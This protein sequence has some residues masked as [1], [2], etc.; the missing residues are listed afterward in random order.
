MKSTKIDDSD[1]EIIGKSL[2]SLQNLRNLDLSGNIIRNTGASQL[3][4]ALQQNTKILK[5]HLQGNIDIRQDILD[6][7]ERI[8]KRNK[9]VII[10]ENR[11]IQKE[12]IEN[13]E[14]F[15][16]KDY[17][18]QND[19][20]LEFENLE[21]IHEDLREKARYLKKICGKELEVERM[22]QKEKEIELSRL[23]D[24]IKTNEDR[25]KE[26]AL[27]LSAFLS[28]N[29]V[30]KAEKE[31]L[32]Q[33]FQLIQ[34]KNVQ[35]LGYI[36]MQI[37]ENSQKFL[38]IDRLHKE[39]FLHF[40]NENE[41]IINQIIG[42]YE[43]K[44]HRLLDIYQHSEDRKALL[45][46]R[47]LELREEALNIAMQFEEDLRNFEEKALMEDSKRYQSVY[48]GKEAELLDLRN[49]IKFNEMRNNELKKEL[50]K[51][52]EKTFEKV[53][54]KELDINN[55]KLEIN[56]LHHK[57]SEINLKRERII[58]LNRVEEE[59][60][61]LFQR[62]IWDIQR[63]INIDK[64]KFHYTI[65]TLEEEHSQESDLYRLG[66]E[67]LH[68]KILELE[69]RIHIK[70]EEN[71]RIKVDYERL[72]NEV[73]GNIGKTLRGVMNS[74]NGINTNDLRANPIMLRGNPLEMRENIPIEAMNHG[75]I[76]NGGGFNNNEEFINPVEMRGPGGFFYEPAQ[77]SFRGF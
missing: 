54:A 39:E 56:E 2:K 77:F 38:E 61:E 66:K 50:E 8:L 22:R 4:L 27:K 25:K 76:T 64:E 60:I 14:E 3:F 48:Q 57:L 18:L 75:F 35:N 20:F 24:I 26:I 49:D 45:E 11:E 30:L 59:K 73:N 13:N 65:E 53:M 41:G 31:A 32:N 10:K 7:I 71:A 63:E 72:M 42:E 36:K 44:Y 6:D 47:V 69:K 46:E 9:L 21:E 28:E 40:S 1:C 62:K 33:E 16:K 12:N 68:A 37:S 43:E 15:I 67:N 29:S 17:F 19:R 51:R 23:R 52:Q 34:K 70:S 5:L 74:E 55:E 58:M